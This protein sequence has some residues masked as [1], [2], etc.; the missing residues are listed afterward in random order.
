LDH[1]T[2]IVL[3]VLL[4]C[5]FSYTNGFQDGSSVAASPIAS[6]SIPPAWAALLS[7]IFEFLGALLGGQAVAGSIVGITR[8]GGSKFLRQPFHGIFLLAQSRCLVLQ[9]MPWWAA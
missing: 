8:Y 4:G 2:I 6:R 1:N 3:I 7:G 5:L 9:R